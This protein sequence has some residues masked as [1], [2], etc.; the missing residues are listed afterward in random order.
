MIGLGLALALQAG[1]LPTVGDTV[2]FERVIQA[3]AHV[4]VRPQGWDLGAIG[5]QLGPAVARRT[6][7][8]IL[9]RYPV[10]FWYPGR[11]ALT[12]PGPVVITPE[13]RSDT[14]PASVATI[15]VASVLPAGRD[16]AAL[17]PRPARP[18]VLLRERRI[19]PA[20]I[21][22]GVT[23]LGI[24]LLA[25]RRRR[26]GIAPP[27]PAPPVARPSTETLAA[28]ARAGEFHAALDHWEHRLALDLREVKDLDRMAAV[29]KVLEAIALAAY[30][31]M[32]PRHLAEICARAEQVSRRA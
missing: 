31:P 4:L 15:D 17:P 26:R 5:R 20:L 13:G 29:Q 25:V 6:E 2:W 11:H 19:R 18:P 22:L 7:R 28:W 16:R 3:P 30:E 32:A 14:L 24:A 8:G 21:F 12:V 9:V 10:V 23:G 1:G 27:R